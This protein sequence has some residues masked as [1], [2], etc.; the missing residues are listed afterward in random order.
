MASKVTKYQIVCCYIFLEI[1]LRFVCAHI[2]IELFAQCAFLF[3]FNHQF[4]N[5]FV[6]LSYFGYVMMRNYVIF[7]FGGK[8]DW[9]FFFSSELVMQDSL[10]SV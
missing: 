4:T 1:T 8:N 5:K 7:V 9:T 3:S 10:V 2:N 6:S